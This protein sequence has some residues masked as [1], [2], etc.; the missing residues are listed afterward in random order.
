MSKS[1]CIYAGRFYTA[2]AM[3]DGS[4]VVERKRPLKNGNRGARLSA[5]SPHNNCADWIAN[6]REAAKDDPS[7]AHMLCRV[8]VQ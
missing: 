4:L 1:E 7:E 6:I 5:D 2:Y 3:R 8:L